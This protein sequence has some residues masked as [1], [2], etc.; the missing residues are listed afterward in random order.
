MF[1][2]LELELIGRSWVWRSDISPKYGQLSVSF[3]A[4]WRL[5]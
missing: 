4:Y 2:S 3:Q 1:S 5:N